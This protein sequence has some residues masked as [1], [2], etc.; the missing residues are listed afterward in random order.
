[1]MWLSTLSRAFGVSTLKSSRAASLSFRAYFA[2]IDRAC[3][4]VTASGAAGPEAMASSRSPSTSES[5]IETTRAGAQSC[6]NRPPLTAERRFLMALISVMSA[7]QA[8]SCQVM[9][10]S[11][12]GGISGF[13]NSAE[14]PPEIRNSTV[15]PSPSGRTISMA[16]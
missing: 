10:C 8:S 3:S 2:A 7:P 9:S 16:A 12:S 1:M 11:A 13:S 15:S 6:A 14:P 5:M 4:Q